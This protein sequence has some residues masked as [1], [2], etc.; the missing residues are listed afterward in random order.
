MENTIKRL[1]FCRLC[2]SDDLKILFIKYGFEVARCRRCGFT[3]LNFDPNEQFIKNY[4]SEDF[5]NDPGTKHGFSDYEAENE[6]LKKTFKERIDILKKYKP[7]GRLLDI[8]CATGTFM[9]VASQNWDVFGVEI[10]EY[11]S[12]KAQEKGLKVLQGDLVNSPYADQKFDIIT[13]WDTLEHLNHPTQ[14]LQTLKKMTNTGSIIAATTGDVGSLASILTGKYWHLFNI[15]QHLSYFDKKSASSLFNKA[16]FKVMQIS[17]PSVNFSL[18]Y[19]LFRLM[20]FYRIRAL[21]SLYQLL[22]RRNLL[23]A[24]FKVNLF[25]IMFIIA[26]RQ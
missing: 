9:E 10:S 26:Q 2:R 22:K 24:N 25:D 1:G 12:Q 7:A 20:T 18:D 3:L 11:A 16:G 6:N 14:V 23:N 5:F 13:M 4:Y 17:Y 15:P 21:K 19:L 8:G